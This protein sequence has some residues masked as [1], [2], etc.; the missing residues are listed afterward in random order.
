MNQDIEDLVAR[1]ARFRK[2]PLDEVLKEWGKKAELIEAQLQ[3]QNRLS[4]VEA[5]LKD[6]RITPFQAIAMLRLNPLSENEI[7]LVVADVKQTL[8]SYLIETT[9]YGIELDPKMNLGYSDPTRRGLAYANWKRRKIVLPT[10]G[11]TEIPLLA[12]VSLGEACLMENSGIFR[13]LKEAFE[14]KEFA[15]FRFARDNAALIISGL[16]M[17]IAQLYA[18]A[19]DSRGGVKLHTIVAD[20]ALRAMEHLDKKRKSTSLSGFYQGFQL[21]QQIAEREGIPGVL[22]AAF[23][24]TTNDQLREYAAGN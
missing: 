4:A 16:P 11:G 19:R 21:F 7:M 22:N 15:N 10:E 9:D 12:S 5:L 6:A 18:A 1:E 3:P 17:F 8:S 24:L 23:T 14:E 2:Q 13:Y 20:T